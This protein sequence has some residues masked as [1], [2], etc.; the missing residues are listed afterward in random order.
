MLPYF[1]VLIISVSSLA[2]GL[3][4]KG[5]KQ[6]GA[7]LFF[8]FS[9]FPLIALAAFRGQW[10]GTDTYT[11]LGFWRDFTT[12]SYQGSDLLFSE[13]LFTVLQH[14][15]RFLADNTFFEQ[16]VFLG[17]ISLI[18]CGLTFS[19]ILTNSTYKL[20]SWTFF[21]LLSFYT[22]HFNGARQ[23]IA[24]ALFLYSTKYILN[25]NQKK[26]AMII[27]VGFLVHKTMLICLPLYFIF[28]RE[29][30]V[31][32]VALVVV[33]A[34]IAAFSISTLVDIATE[35]DQRYKS[36][37]NKEAA[38]GGLV[39]VLFNTS[40]LIWLW[41]SKKVNAINLKLYDISLLSMLIAVCIGWVSVILSLNPSGILRLSVYFTQFS[42]FSLPLS[43]IYYKNSTTRGFVLICV[44]A[45]ASL[46]FYLTTTS[47]SGLTPYNST[48]NLL[49]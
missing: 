28:R 31:Q 37:A 44:L 27:I 26:Y 6:P 19:A 5:N 8:F 3:W 46:Y 1:I 7:N 38:G 39:T 23:A 9:L 2:V 47:F 22:F 18:V 41:F 35:Y 20:M 43:I 29:L 17:A 40:L 45:V 33:G 42:I 21:I 25:G 13:P 30:N 4:L 16:E 24:I 12:S 34:V 48:F 11:Y 14:A 10:V 15:T 32:Q 36:Y 49:F